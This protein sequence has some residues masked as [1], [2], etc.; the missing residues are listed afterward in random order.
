MD[1]NPQQTFY[2]GVP[3]YATVQRWEDGYTAY[4]T[5]MPGIAEHGDS[6]TQAVEKLRDAVL[7]TLRAESLR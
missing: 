3:I 2:K 6:A 5:D 1:E 7:F 4:L